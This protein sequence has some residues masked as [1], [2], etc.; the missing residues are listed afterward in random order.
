MKISNAGYIAKGI[1]FVLLGIIIAFMPNVISLFFYITGG[2]IILGCIGSIL[3]SGGNSAISGA[4]IGGI[5]V[6][7]VVIMLPKIIEAS[8][9]VIAGIVFIYFG[10]KQLYKAYKSDKP[11]DSKI[12]TVI[13][14]ALLIGIG[15][16]LIANPFETG[17]IARVAI[18][19]AVILLGAFNFL[20][21]HTIAQR[22]KSISPDVINVSDF[23]V[24]DDHKLLK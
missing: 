21:A 4:G 16:F 12:I 1:I 19:I 2:I 15:I 5:I 9:P 18:G 23:N 20:V 22:N 3:S 11:K 17:K 10:I 13:F 24:N 14:G 7:I 6:G 8:I